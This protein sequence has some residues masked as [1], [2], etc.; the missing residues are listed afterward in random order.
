MSK[1]Q[2]EN[3]EQLENRLIELI[4]SQKNKPALE[5]E[6]QVSPR[7]I[8]YLCNVMSQ[9][10]KLSSAQ[11]AESTG[12]VDTKRESSIPISYSKR[13]NQKDN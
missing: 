11:K 13:H 5:P 8:K 10:I 2:Q 9:E 3:S 4:S 6:R 12:Y 1:A 7:T